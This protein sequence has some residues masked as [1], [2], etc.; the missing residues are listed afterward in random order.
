MSHYL[1]HNYQHSCPINECNTSGFIRNYS[2]LNLP[3]DVINI[4]FVYYFS[5][6]IGRN[7]AMREIIDSLIKNKN[8]HILNIYGD[9]GVGKTAITIMISRYLNDRK[10]YFNDGIY[11]INSM[12]L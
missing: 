1:V 5:P 3:Q 10:I 11:Y 4:I 2:K 7:I 12:E 8:C 6:F 9:N